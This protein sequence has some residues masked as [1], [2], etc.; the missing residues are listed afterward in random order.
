MCH[1]CTD[2]REDEHVTTEDLI[3]DVLIR[4]DKLDKRLLQ[5]SKAVVRI[6]ESLKSRSA[7]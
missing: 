1:K 4:L 3:R 6:E 2:F 5:I 7:N